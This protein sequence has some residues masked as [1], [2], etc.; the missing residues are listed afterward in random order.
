MALDQ[1][2]LSIM[3]MYKTEKEYQTPKAIPKVTKE[4]AT[5]IQP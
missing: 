3:A 1:E 4:V 5:I 2:K